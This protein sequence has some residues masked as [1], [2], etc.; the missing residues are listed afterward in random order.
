M[1]SASPD[2]GT[3]PGPGTIRL[4]SRDVAAVSD[5]HLAAFPTNVWSR[6]GG[7]LLRTYIQLFIESPHALA[8]G[9]LPPQNPHGPGDTAGIAPV[10][11][12]VGILDARRHRQWVW[13]NGAARLGLALLPAMLRHP[14]LFAGLV[15]RRLRVATRRGE[16]TPT[17]RKAERPRPA[18]PVA[19]LSHVAVQPEWRGLGLGE[20]LV[21][22]FLVQARHAGA[23]CAYLATLDEGGAGAWYE[24]R[25]WT[26]DARRQTFDGR[27]IRIYRHDLNQDGGA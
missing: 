8:V 11:H 24:A 18:G 10:G 22:T 12:L 21:D 15:R 5:M 2:P 20:A 16:G 1:A 9:A 6:F 25:D 27:W 13:R 23:G 19:V 17:S 4:T 14:L 7:R 3:P 26:L